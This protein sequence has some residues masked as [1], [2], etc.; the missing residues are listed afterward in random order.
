MKLVNLTGHEIKILT[1][2]NQIE[3]IP[4]SGLVARITTSD[5][6]REILDDNY[7]T[8]KQRVTKIIDLPEQQ[9]EGIYYIVSHVVLAACKK[10]MPKR[11][12]LLAPN[13]TTGAIKENGT[14]QYVTSL[15]KY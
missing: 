15:I 2:K 13:T 8:Y 7:V 9:T 12:D 1:T 3:I 11:N 5:Y 10:V 4:P 6:N 14:V